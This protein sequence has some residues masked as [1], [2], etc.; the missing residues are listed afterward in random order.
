MNFIAELKKL[1][2]EEEPSPLDPLAELARAH[3][4]LLEALNKNSSGISLQVEEIYDIVKESNEN[5]REVKSAAKRES[6]LLTAMIAINDLLDSMFKYIQYAGGTHSEAITA[7]RA[8]A[9]NACSLEKIGL[10]GQHLDPRIHTVATAEYSGAP[11]ETVIRILEN[12]YM[13]RGNVVRKATVIVSKGS[14]NV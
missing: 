10:L 12:G 9:L 3:A 5:A 11:A 14:E 1:L 2:G 8:E 4:E 7:K 13:Y 6:T